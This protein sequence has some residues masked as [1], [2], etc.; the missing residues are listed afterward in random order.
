M[1]DG[2]IIEE[3]KFRRFWHGFLV[4]NLVN[5][6]WLKRKRIHQI[7]YLRCCVPLWI[8]GSS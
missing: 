4:W 3:L 6:S 1:G 2:T 8:V 5:R 7:W